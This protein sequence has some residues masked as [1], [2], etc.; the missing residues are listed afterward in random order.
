VCTDRVAADYNLS[1]SMI[2]DAS[3][4]LAPTGLKFTTRGQ[5]ARL[6]WHDANWYIDGSGANIY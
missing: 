4:T 3:G 1:S 5:T 6:V 2:I